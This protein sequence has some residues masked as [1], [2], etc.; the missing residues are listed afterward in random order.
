[1]ASSLCHCEPKA[2]SSLTFSPFDLA[3]FYSATVISPLGDIGIV[4]ALGAGGVV[5][6]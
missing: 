5:L 3:M 1:M 2:W 6:P 4:F